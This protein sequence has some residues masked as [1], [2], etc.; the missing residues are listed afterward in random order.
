MRRSESLWNLSHNYKAS[1]TNM[2]Y[3]SLAF[4][5]DDKILAAGTTTGFVQLFE[6]SKR[7]TWEQVSM[8][9]GSSWKSGYGPVSDFTL[10]DMQF[11]P[12]ERNSMPFLTASKDEICLWNVSHHA[13]LP[14]GYNFV[15]HGLEFPPLMPSGE[16]TLSVAEAL[17]IHPTTEGKFHA[18]RASNDG[19]MF[20]YTLNNSLRMRRVDRPDAE[21]TVYESDTTLMRMDFDPNQN[22]IVVIGDKWG[23][24]DL[25]DMRVKP[26]TDVPTRRWDARPILDSRFGYVSDVRFS[27]DGK[28]FVSRHYSDLLFWDRRAHN[29]WPLKT[30]ELCHE[31][32]TRNHTFTEKGR[33]I[34]RTVWIDSKTVATGSFAE[35]LFMITTD[36]NK[37]VR[38]VNETST[39][40]RKN[41]WRLIG[42]KERERNFAREHCVHVVERGKT[43]IAATNGAEI[44]I[45]DI[46]K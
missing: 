11:I 35:A 25:L 32:E 19:L 41:S 45:Y 8:F 46:G 34:F 21:L 6:L 15:A 29:G 12:L 4:S 3:S 7:H 9:P 40:E 10:M 44:F 31:C 1:D 33:D 23:R 17:L 20:G 24:I 36:G 43:R 13:G 28:T 26:T 22:E 14:A 18:A 38:Y 16:A 27:P 39:R 37:S 30:V 5:S 2:V 42:K